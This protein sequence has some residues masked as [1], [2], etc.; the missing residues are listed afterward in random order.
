[1]VRFLDLEHGGTN[2]LDP[3]ARLARVQ[4]HVGKVFKEYKMDLNKQ[5]VQLEVEL[6]NRHSHIDGNYMREA[7]VA[8]MADP[9]VKGQVAAL[10]L[11][12]GATVVVEPWTYGTDGLNDM[13]KRMTM[14]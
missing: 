5:A 10:K 14:V 6:E 3:P 8:C 2:A 7:E 1:M 11:P 13:S 12:E 9:R 4:A